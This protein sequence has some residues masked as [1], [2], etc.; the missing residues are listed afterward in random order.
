MSS[1]ISSSNPRSAS[2]ANS[3]VSLASSR[4]S[5]SS[6]SG[7]QIQQQPDPQEPRQPKHRKQRLWSTDRKKICMCHRDNPGMKQEEIA[8]RFGVERSTVS[9]ILKEKD[10]WLNVK[11]DEKLQVA[12]WR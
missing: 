4:T 11:D 6:A 10:R 2:P 8:A 1:S 12:K 9:K 7:S 5:F 3:V